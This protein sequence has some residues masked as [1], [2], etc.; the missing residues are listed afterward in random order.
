[1]KNIETLKR[2]EIV[3]LNRATNHKMKKPSK[4]TMRKISNLNNII[5]TQN[6]YAVSGTKS[7][8]LIHAHFKDGGICF[9]ELYSGKIIGLEPSLL[10]GVKFQNGRCELIDF[11]KI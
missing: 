11:S 10:K 1:M 3:I 5:H 4:E 7:R 6:L 9:E 8:R 2:N